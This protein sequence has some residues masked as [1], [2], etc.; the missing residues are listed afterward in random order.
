MSGLSLQQLNQQLLARIDPGDAAQVERNGRDGLLH[1]QGAQPA[2]P[3]ELRFELIGFIA[4][5]M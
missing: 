1:D 5:M 3:F 2:Q 4:D